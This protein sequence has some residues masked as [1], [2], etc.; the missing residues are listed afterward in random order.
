MRE[1]VFLYFKAISRRR[2]MLAALALLALC[3]L[4][5]VPFL[6]GRTADA[7]APAPETR[8]LPVV[9]Y[10]SLLRDPARWGDYVVSP[11]QLERDLAYLQEQGYVFVTMA[12]VIGF[13]SGA[14]TLPEKPALLTLDDGYLNNRVYLPEILARRDA[15]A[16]IAAV[17]EY[18]DLF[19]ARE[20]H[21]PSYAH[22]TWA[23][24]RDFAAE[25]RVELGCHSY[26]FHHQ[27][28]RLGASRRRGESRS[29]W[30]EALCG[31]ARAMR[32]RLTAQCGV[33]PR[34][35][36]IPTGRSA[37]AR[38]PP[39]GRWALRPPSPAMSGSPCCGAATPTVCIPSAATTAPP[40]PQA[41]NS[42]AGSSGPA[43]RRS[44]RARTIK[45]RIT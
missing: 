37:T 20:D 11:A 32:D 29:A 34:V 38:T 33:T 27:G 14:G 42:S 23:E 6:L 36:S 16:V 21:N 45:A 12:E 41:R 24:L 4:L 3:A 44:K 5:L 13:V 35:M 40:G 9:M 1:A 19:T 17:G 39:C 18:A 10:H 7:F 31:D 26:Y 28:A 22:M 2:L 43:P 8:A 15:H 25:G 30:L